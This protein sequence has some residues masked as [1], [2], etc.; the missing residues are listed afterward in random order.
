ML[1][2]VASKFG[3]SQTDHAPAEFWSM[4]PYYWPRTLPAGARLYATP[5]FDTARR[6]TCYFMLIDAQRSRAV[7]WVKSY[8]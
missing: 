1:E 3:M 7:V 5:D 8:F 2:T 6:G 4:S